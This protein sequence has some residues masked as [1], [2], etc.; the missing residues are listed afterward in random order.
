MMGIMMMIAGLSAV[1][2]AVAFGRA[3]RSHGL[4]W[5]DGRSWT[6]AHWPRLCAE[7]KAMGID[8]IV[9]GTNGSEN[10]KL[11]RADGRWSAE[12]L[13]Q[14]AAPRNAPRVHAMVWAAPTATFLASF[15]RYC[16]ELQQTGIRVVELDIEREVWGDTPVSGFPSKEAAADALLQAAL[17]AGLVVG[18][19]MIPDRVYPGF[20]RADYIAIQSYSR[21]A[22]GADTHRPGGNY[23]PGAMQERGARAAKRAGLPLVQ[24]LAAYDQQFSGPLGPEMHTAYDAAHRT[25]KVIR[26]WSS[27]WVIGANANPDVRRVIEKLIQA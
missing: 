27:K 5:D 18:V 22:G 4:W 20:E 19:T 24:G 7:L 6:L 13:A 17:D 23:G 2:L 26:W 11:G 15:K 21:F 12:Q 8:H 14:L 1:T 3:S 25:S 9:V 10:A 16:S